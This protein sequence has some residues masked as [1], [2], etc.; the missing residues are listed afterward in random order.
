MASKKYHIDTNNKITFIKEVKLDSLPNQLQESMIQAI[1]EEGQTEKVQ[2][3]E[4][5][6]KKIRFKD[7][8]KDA[9]KGR[10][11]VMLN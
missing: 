9:I 11:S 5:F 8:M 2:E 10:L 6:Y 1:D 3:A 4:K 7:K